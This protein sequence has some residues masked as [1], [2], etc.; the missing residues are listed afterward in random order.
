MADRCYDGLQDSVL[1]SSGFPCTPLHDQNQLP[2]R[3]SGFDAFGVPRFSKLHHGS[4]CF[5]DPNAAPFFDSI[6]A[7]NEVRPLVSVMENVVGLLRHWEKARCSGVFCNCYCRFPNQHVKSLQTPSQFSD[8]RSAT[9]PTKHFKAG[10]P[11]KNRMSNS[12]IV[13]FFREVKGKPYHS[14]LR[15]IFW[16]TAQVMAHTA[17]LRKHYCMTLLRID[18]KKFGDPVSRPRVYIVFVRQ[19]HACTPLSLTC[20]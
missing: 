15:R 12:H 16:Q 9:L 3:A 10:V 14:S 1:H 7:V 8:E 11:I 18:A 5:Q 2:K 19:S 20:C 4:R 17:P 6:S 13:S